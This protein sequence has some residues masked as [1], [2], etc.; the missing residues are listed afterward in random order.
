MQTE[1]EIIVDRHEIMSYHVQ[2][3]TL[4]E[5]KRLVA[6]GKAGEGKAVSRK[7]NI[8]CLKFTPYKDA[9]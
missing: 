5:A 1:Y 3:Q 9:A 8:Y 6:E 2:A 4:A 7:D